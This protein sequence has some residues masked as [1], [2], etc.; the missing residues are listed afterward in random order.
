MF[1]PRPIKKW[2]AIF[3]G[4]VS[5]ILILLSVT[6]GFWFGL[7]PGFYGLHVAL[8]VLALIFNTHFGL[9]LLAAA[10]GKSLALA[11]APVLYHVGVFTQD[12]LGP[13]LALLAAVPIVGITDFSR[14]AVAGAVVV[15]PAVGLL[16]GAGLAKSVL[17]YRKAWLKL[18]ESSESFKRWREKKWVRV[19]DR[20]L[21][22]K[23]AKNV[24]E[25]LARRPKI[26][27]RAGVALALLFFAGAGVGAKFFLTDEMLTARAAES[28]TRLNGAQVDIERLS[29]KPFSGKIAVTGVQVTDPEKPQNNRVSIDEFQAQASLYS[30][31]LGKVVIDNLVISAL[32]FDQPR[33]QPGVVL[34]DAKQEEESSEP[35]NWG[36][37]DLRDVDAQQLDTYFKNAKKIKETLAKIQPYLP[38]PKAKEA[39]EPTKVP[40]RYLEYLSARA[41]TA[42]SPR[43]VARR[44]VLDHVALPFG[45]LAD[46]KIECHNLSDAPGAAAMPVT[47][48]ITSN[49]SADW[50]QIVS[51]Y[52][53]PQ[54]GA[55]ITAEFND[56][57]LA[58]LQKDL[59]SKNP[60]VFKG[61]TASARIDGR[62]GRDMIDLGIKVNTHNLT[63]E[64]A[65]GGAGA[66]ALGLDPQITGEA[67]KVL[68]NID[69]T[70]RLVGPI[71]A[72][73]LVFDVSALREEFRAALLKA[74]KDQLA[75]RLGDLI[76]DK[77]PIG[78]EI[79]KDLDPATIGDALSGAVGDL[80]G[81]DKPADKD[82]PDKKEEEKKDDKKDA[83]DILK[84]IGGLFGGEKSKDKNDAP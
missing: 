40:E 51:H 6:F 41:P 84:D 47:V 50:M 63:I 62:L 39:S 79:P 61:G 67:L 53:A 24:R 83:K 19:L 17:S 12:A 3:R 68:E 55:Q 43:F 8:L 1:I 70:L 44:V 54:Q 80:L 22:G 75:G 15:G 48:K 7:T 34:A 78:G 81:K 11:G 74:G 59:S 10:L 25:T 37:Y 31:L 2:V 23:S 73:K 27:R 46:S 30:L 33:A 13:L 72:P 20:V 14:Y 82:D 64:S 5:P 35:F 71:T 4:E 32:K 21:V 69:T 28:L 49:S 65:G 16:L 56:I 38:D 57:D 26:I 18:D 29:L 45:K 76:G 77:L 42:P 66:G 58:D 9:F 60:V 36:Q 52:E